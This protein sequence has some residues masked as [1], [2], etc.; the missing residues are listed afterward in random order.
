MNDFEKITGDFGIRIAIIGTLAVL[1]LF[2]LA[3]TVAVVQNLGRSE[4]SATET[5][6]VFG[7]GKANVAPDVARITFSVQNSSETVSEAQ[8][9]TTK[10][11]NATI[12][13]ARSQ[14]IEDKDIKTLSY[15]VYPKYEYQRPCSNGALCPEYYSNT[16]RIVGYQVS[17]TIQLTV[18]DLDSTGTILGGIGALE[19]QNISGPNLTLDDP[20]AGYNV[21]RADAIA[22][23]KIQARTLAKQ[24]GVRLG[25][26]VSFSESKGNNGYYARKLSLESSYD[27]ES[28]ATPEIPTGENEY[29]ANVSITYEIR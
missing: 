11:A 3:Q 23:A 19:V 5:I 13:Y 7:S 12:D 6:T 22:E 25:G 2:L 16:P 28:V 20:T 10:Q 29:S 27:G 8:T 1:G 21:A 17:Q 18:R 24:L 14:G 9:E 26:I 4:Y 15:N